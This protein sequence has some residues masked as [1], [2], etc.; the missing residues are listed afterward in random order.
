MKPSNSNDSKASKDSKSDAPGILPVA[1]VALEHHLKTLTGPMTEWLKT[2]H[3]PPVLLLSGLAGIGKR[4]IGY[5]LAQWI[6]CE[7]VGFSKSGEADEG[8]SL[9]GGGLFGEAPAAAPVQTVPNEVPRTRP[10]G[11]CIQCQRALSGSWVDFTEITSDS[12]SDEGSTASG[13]LKID[14]FRRLKETAGFGAHEGAHRVIL[15][16]NADRMTPQAANSVLKI[17]EE[18]PRGWIFIL[19]ASDPTLVLPTVLSRCQSLKLKPMDSA[20]IR[21]LLSDAGILGEKQKVSALLCEGSWGRALSLANDDVLEHRQI[22]FNFLERPQGVLGSLVDWAA[23]SPEKLGLLLDQLEMI[24]LD[25]IRASVT[26]AQGNGQKYAWLNVDGAMALQ[27][28]ATFL[29]QRLGSVEGARSFWIARSERIAQARREALA[30]LNRKLLIQD[31]LMPW[32]EA[33]S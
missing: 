9:F 33:A 10:C 13:T 15:I 26:P 2:H 20:T 3:L 14:Q 19:T 22:L 21:L 12:D 4:S 24:S 7:R 17:L 30:P 11:E 23:Q 8:D 6:S 28:H 16:P 32:L 5:F 29:T 1:E 18:P 27:N 31:V 25:L